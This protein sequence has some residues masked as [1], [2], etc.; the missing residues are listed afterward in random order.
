MDDTREPSPCVTETAIN[1]AIEGNSLG[2]I[3]IN[4]VVSGGIGAVAG[5]AGSDF[6]KGGKL[7]NEAAESI[8]KK[9]TH[10]V[11]KK[12]A[13]KTVKRALRKTWGVYWRTQVEDLGFNGIDSFSQLL[14]ERAFE[15]K[16]C[17]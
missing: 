7:I 4:S 15:R 14:T 8:T 11:A 17:R 13:K 16:Y 5:S 2:E 6:V 9:A 12:A 1:G 3:A 10:P